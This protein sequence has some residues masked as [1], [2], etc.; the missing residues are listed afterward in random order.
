MRVWAVAVVVA[1]CVASV[2]S[3]Q[4]VRPDGKGGARVRTGPPRVVVDDFDDVS[5]WSAH[6]ADGVTLALATDEDVVS[7]TMRLDVHFVTGGGY[8][9]ARR[10]VSLDLPANYRF[11]LHVRGDIGP[12]DLEFKLIDSTGANVWWCNRRNFVFPRE[13]TE[14]VTRKRD[15]SFAWGPAGG[16]EPRHIAAIEFAVT[17]GSGGQ[18]SVWLDDLVLEELPVPPAVPPRPVASASSGAARPAVDGV[19]RTAWTTARGDASPW[20]MLDF[21][22]LREFGGLTLDWAPG[23]ALRD[24]DVDLSDDH[25]TWRPARAVRGG[26]GGRDHVYTP[27]SEARYVRVRAASPAPRGC[28]LAEVRVRD[29]PWS[30]TMKAARSPR[31]ACTTSHGP[32]R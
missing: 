29:V 30:A 2:A 17:A 7:R 18:G 14:L 10:A 6:P 27:G 32:R 31:Y 24:Y 25:E 21:G 28:A 15:I 9:V 12:E 4:D 23:R 20:L 11:R 16:G 26:D 8:A 1:A 5:P 3:A 13:W 22:Y 19:A